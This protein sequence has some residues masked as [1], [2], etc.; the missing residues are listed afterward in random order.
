ML[1]PLHPRRGSHSTDTLAPAPSPGLCSY[2]T[3]SLLPA[4]RMYAQPTPRARRPSLQP[5]RPPSPTLSF[6]TSLKT[7]PSTFPTTKTLKRT[8]LHFFARRK[9]TKPTSATASQRTD[10]DQQSLSN[11]IP[12]YTPSQSI[13][14]PS[15]S[16]IPTSDRPM[17]ASPARP[18]VPSSPTAP[19]RAATTRASAPTVLGEKKDDVY[20]FSRFALGATRRAAKVVK[21]KLSSLSP[22]SSLPRT[23]EEYRDRYAGVRPCEIPQQCDW[24]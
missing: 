6:S 24:C 12:P 2:L 18:A 10:R 5:Q 15:Y 9:G 23:W 20:S 1:A 14:S 16:R 3:T 13:A 7:S 11:A 21:R 19:S 17:P 4:P 8:M 22:P